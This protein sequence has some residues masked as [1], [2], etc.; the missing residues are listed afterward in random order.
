MLRK[1]D[2]IRYFQLHNDGGY[3]AEMT[4]LYRAAGTDDEWKSETWGENIKKGNSKTIDA[5]NHDGEQIFKTGTEIKLKMTVIGGDDYKA[6]D[7][8]I[9]DTSSVLLARYISCG[10]SQSTELG[11]EKLTEK[12]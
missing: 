7:S 12:D 2:K 5:G 9:Y 4:V 6:F 3:I 1:D 10:G 11:F 8:F